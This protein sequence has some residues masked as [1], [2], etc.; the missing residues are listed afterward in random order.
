MR[1]H[2]SVEA[3]LRIAIVCIALIGLSSVCG[4]EPV[5]GPLTADSRDQKKSEYSYS[6]N[7]GPG[8]WGE[9]DA[10][11]TDC[12]GDARQS[13]ID[14]EVAKP[15]ASLKPLALS[16]HEVPIN[17]VNNGHTIEQEYEPGSTLSF[18][19]VD[20]ELVQFHFHT[21]SEHEIE[22]IRGVME[23]HAVFKNSKTGNL[24]VIGQLFRIGK[25]NEFLK[26]FDHNLPEHTGDHTTLKK[27][28]N[29][30]DVFKNSRSYFTYQGSLTTPPCSPIV[31]WIVL[32]KDISIS[33]EQF[34]AFNHIL[35]NNF[36]PLQPLN[37]RTVRSTP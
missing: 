16:I 6:G 20:Y 3:S 22:G 34:H 8:H 35:G 4:A 19:G 29:I 26:A 11:W 28:I 2:V 17:L 9:I 33:E 23:L 15:D 1:S 13:P 32:K 30:G 24:A 7:E 31:T 27:L 18:G 5:R 21:L 14:I 10:A 25:E 36:R 37:G 12:E